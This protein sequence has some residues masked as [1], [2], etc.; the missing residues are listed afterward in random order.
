MSRAGV[1]LAVVVADLI[2]VGAPSLAVAGPR[3]GGASADA[4]DSRADI[5]AAYGR[6]QRWDEAAALLLEAHADRPRDGDILEDLVVACFHSERCAPRRAALLHEARTRLAHPSDLVDELSELAEGWM[7]EDK[8]TDAL[9]LLDALRAEG[10]SNDLLEDVIDACLHA[11]SCAPRR[12]GLL[13]QGVTRLAKPA[14]LVD[15]YANELFKAL[16]PKQALSELGA[17][18]ARHRDDDAIAE[19][20][21]SAAIDHEALDLEITEL[22]RWLA[23]HP[24]D[25]ERRIAYVEALHERH[26]DA[27]YQRELDALLRL[28]PTNVTALSLRTE[29]RLERGDVPAARRELDR[30]RTL[31][32]SDDERARVRELDEE[33]RRTVDEQKRDFRRE[34]GWL[35]LADDLEREYDREP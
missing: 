8:W 22:P 35:D 11:P 14:E 12:L 4:G 15:D 2:A 25:V 23:R 5:A 3:G 1:V 29:A 10:D 6:K 16:P 33:L 20:L 34:S 30:L 31:A 28:S 24:D 21:V 17:F 9:A 26:R 7:H 13:R 19:A 27:E 32:R 18:A